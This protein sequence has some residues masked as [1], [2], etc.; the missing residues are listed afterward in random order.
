MVVSDPKAFVEAAEVSVAV[1]QAKGARQLCRREGVIGS[2]FLLVAGRLV[3]LF[4]R[5]RH[6][7]DAVVALLDAATQKVDLQMLVDDD[8]AS[9][10]LFLRASWAA[11]YKAFSLLFG[12]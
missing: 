2:L 4:P 11:F 10:R 3:F 12:C 9:W 6:V 5:Q 8:A 1:L 7:E